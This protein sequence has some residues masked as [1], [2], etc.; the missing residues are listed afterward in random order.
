MYIAVLMGGGEWATIIIYP[1]LTYDEE[2]QSRTPS[3]SLMMKINTGRASLNIIS[4]NPF[5]PFT[6]KLRL[7]L[8]KPQG[9]D[10]D[11]RVIR[12]G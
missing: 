12:L 2:W 1:C 9:D 8:Q 4:M 10:N 5:T 11:T 7:C 3:G 6:D